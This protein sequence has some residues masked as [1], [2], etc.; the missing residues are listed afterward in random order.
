MQKPESIKVLLV[1]D[2]EHDAELVTRELRRA[3]IDFHS[4][5]VQRLARSS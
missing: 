5:R 2:V 4:R 1:E 3:G